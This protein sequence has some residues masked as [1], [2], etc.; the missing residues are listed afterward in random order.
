MKK[1][2]FLTFAILLLIACNGQS[3]KG[4]S[5]NAEVVTE[6]TIEQPKPV[7]NV[8]IE[9]S[10]SMDGYVKGKTE[11]ENA[12]YSYLSDI[13]ISDIPDSLNLFYINSEVIPQGSDISDFIEKLEPSTFKKKGGDRGTS[14]IANVIKDVLVKTKG[15]EIAILVTDGIFSPGR[16]VDATEYLGNQQIGIKRSMSDYLKKYPNTAV[17]IYQLS[18][19]FNGTYYDKVD[20]RIP[21]NEQRPFYIWIIGDKKQVNKLRNSVPDSKFQG[22]GVQNVFTS[23][24]GSQSTKYALNPSIGRYKKTKT[25][26]V[27]KGL[28]KDKSGKIRFAVNVNFSDLLLDDNYLTDIKNYETNSKYTLEVRSNAKNGY[29]HTLY[30][31][32][33]DNRIYK[34]EVLVKLKAEL[35]AWIE[36]VN[37][38]DGSTAAKGKTYG[39]K[40]QLGGVF[41]AFTFSNN[42]YTE[43]KININ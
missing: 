30:F 1:F 37:D 28:K 16:G 34:G 23:T 40:Y 27:I 21:I 41:D 3:R 13:M 33:S 36:M 12:V 5:K 32:S 2:L 43:I 6:S 17:I 39:I 38:D 22:S 29:T 8:Y 35:P 42:Y 14:D 20:T 18:S 24:S 19:N 26:N 15:N 25:T 9:N 10:G 11:F 7:V 31:E 4:T